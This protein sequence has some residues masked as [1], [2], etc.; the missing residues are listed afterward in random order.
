MTIEVKIVIGAIDEVN[1]SPK[2]WRICVSSNKH[3]NDLT[4]AT[5]RSGY[6]RTN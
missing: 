1:K 5:S 3:S 2:H 6:R 4:T